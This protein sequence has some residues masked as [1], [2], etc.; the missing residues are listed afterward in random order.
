MRVTIG[1]LARSGLELHGGG[2]LDATVN[3]ALLY[4]VKKVE[5]GRIPAKY[6]K[7]L[8]GAEA[9]ESN[10]EGAD[11]GLEIEVDPEVEAELERVAAEQDTTAPEF[12]GHAVLVYLAELD[13]VAGLSEVPE[14]RT[15]A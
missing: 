13:L 3:A 1:P 15:R 9:A 4:Y 12:A 2:N 7:F 11:A 5:S 10:G 8:A 14:R 6:P